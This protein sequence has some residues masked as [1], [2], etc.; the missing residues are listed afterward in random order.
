MVV[1]SRFY[2]TLVSLLWISRRWKMISL[3]RKYNPAM[4]LAT[5]SFW[6][7]ISVNTEID[8]KFKLSTLIL[9]WKDFVS[10]YSQWGSKQYSEKITGFEIIFAIQNI[11]ILHKNPAT[12]LTWKLLREKITWF[13]FCLLIYYKKTY[14]IRIY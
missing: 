14:L 12:V 2:W 8:L 1:N 6:E 7:K 9:L 5:A 10:L 13:E 3:S 11:V 4:F